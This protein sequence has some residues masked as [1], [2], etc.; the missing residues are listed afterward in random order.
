MKD[1][2]KVRVVNILFFLM[3]CLSELIFAFC[4]SFLNNSFHLIV[5]LL[6]FILLITYLYAVFK[7]NSFLTSYLF[8]EII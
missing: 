5:L 2:K 7:E 1:S 6:K 8:N 4:Y 3:E